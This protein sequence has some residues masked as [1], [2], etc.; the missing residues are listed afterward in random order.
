[1]AKSITAISVLLLLYLI[2]VVII[3]AV[4]HTII[5]IK[6]LK[7]DFFQV[8]F[9]YLLFSAAYNNYSSSFLKL[10]N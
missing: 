9:A 2:C 1:M 6:H 4:K 5:S 3:P 10:I 7:S 8:L